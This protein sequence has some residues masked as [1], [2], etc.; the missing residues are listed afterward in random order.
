[1]RPMDIP[2]AKS[3]PAAA[4]DAHRATG[5][6]AVQRDVAELLGAGVAHHQA[7]RLAEA[8]V[9]Y[10]QIL[11]AA[12]EHADALHL[13]GVIAYQVGR[14]DAALELIDQAIRHNGNSSLYYSNR[15]LA[16]QGL[17]RLD[18]AV[19]SY[20]RALALAADN[21]EAWNN[22]GLALHGLMRFEEAVASYDRALAV[23]PDPVGAFNN[24]GNAQRALGRLEE[25]VQSYECALAGRPDLAEAHYNRGDALRDLGRLEEAVA[26]Y[27]RALDLKPDYAEALNNRGLALHR[28]GQFDE[29]VAC[30]DR[31]LAIRP[32]QAAFLINH[33]LALHQ[34]GR[35]E[36]ALASYDR[37]L[38]RNP[39]Y[40]EAL[41]NRGLALHQ[42][43]RFE[44]AVASYDRALAGRPDH[45]EAL[46]NRG[47]ALGQLARS[48]EA[49]E[50]YDRALVLRPNYSQALYNRGRVLH[51]LKRFAEAAASY[52]RALAVNPDYAE[53][54]LS[55]GVALK[56]LERWPEAQAA[57]KA[58]LELKV[59]TSCERRDAV[60]EL[61]ERLFALDCIP[62]VYESASAIEA[63][64][65]RIQACLAGMNDVVTA[66]VDRD[67]D[68]DL[69]PII[70]AIF[71]V[72]GFY[73]AYQQQNDVALM[74]SHAA[75]LGQLLKPAALP[76]PAVVPRS[77][78]IRVGIASGLLANHNGSRWAYDWFCHLPLQDYEIFSY[79]LDPLHDQ[80]TEKFASLGHF[81][82]LSFD[83]L[84]YKDAIGNMRH[85]RLDFLMLPDVGMTSASRVLAQ[86]RIAPAQF[87]AWGHPVTTGSPN[88]D[89]FLSS[90]LMEPEDAQQH[91]SE[92]LVRL[93]N[94]ALFL[95][96]G[97]PGERG[98]AA[99]FGLPNDRVLYGSVQSLFKYL[100]DYDW[101]YP[102]IAKRLPQAFFVF[103]ADDPPRMADVFRDRLARAFAR[104][105]LDL[106]DYVRFLPRMSDERFRSLLGSI[107]I[108][109]DS[110]GWSGGNSTIQSLE[111]GCPLVTLPTEFM[112]GRHSYAMLRMIGVEELIATSLEDFADRLVRLGSDAE[113]RS[114]IVRK[115]EANRHR[116][117]EDYT[118]I[119]ALD[120]FFKDAMRQ[121]CG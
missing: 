60:I 49:L 94:L 70:T 79:A 35:F 4:A 68:K 52:E 87:T 1:M 82:H 40:P 6:A 102:G 41:V 63:E 116:L 57:F 62:A 88:I 90:D 74:A 101:I 15:G 91:Y 120:R 45:P 83:A 117:Y 93:P 114:R 80:V 92:T 99:G 9:R 33:G 97:E 27:D 119:V 96:P 109:I 59:P 39:D 55:F 66:A 5:A 28:L 84:S 86:Y 8:E 2:A 73:I 37:A 14:H 44:E 21:A 22:R 25:A 58:Y 67:D 47:L 13:L 65:M 121:A 23:R 105:G 16:L 115:I 72:S 36:E 10:R 12:P 118:V 108:N 51:R 95:V 7:G 61:G 71:S 104:Q 53:A 46:N 112:R 111:M 106:N 77:G 78:G 103:I 18:E 30:Y 69:E 11:A 85:D 29:A 64:R 17:Q 48:A 19:A 32:D 107:D 110:I 43:D 75:I 50:C 98:T 42:L 24:R 56:V 113:F 81:K 20:D 3:G 54:W 38:A 76:M 89:F 34:L 26:S 100:P 31:V